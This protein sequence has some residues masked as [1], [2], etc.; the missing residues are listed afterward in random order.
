MTLVLAYAGL[1]AAEEYSDEEP[2]VPTVPDGDGPELRISFGVMGGDATPAKVERCTRFA[3][4]F[5]VVIDS[6]ARIGVVLVLSGNGNQL[7][8]N[9]RG[10]VQTRSRPGWSMRDL[11]RDALAHAIDVLYD[12]WRASNPPR[13]APVR[14]SP[15]PP[16]PPR[17]RPATPPMRVP[18]P[19][20]PGSSSGGQAR[21]QAKRFHEAAERAFK[22]QQYDLAIEDWAEALDLDHRPE[23]LHNIG[24]AFQARGEKNGYLSD[25][26]RARTYYRKYIHEAR[27]VALEPADMERLE[28]QIRK[29]EKAGAR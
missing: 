1:G 10:R 9:R 26:R 29:L 14:P 20:P 8:I 15:P 28:E 24:R 11:C 23:F 19:S 25:L 18:A 13:P 17:V 12:D 3:D 22:L 6:E 27:N 5:G 16:L 7:R 2:A 21:S 4:D